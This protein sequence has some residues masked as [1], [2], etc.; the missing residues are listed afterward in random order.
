MR[1]KEAAMNKLPRLP[2]LPG[3]GVRPYRPCPPDFREV[4][5]QLS[6]LREIEEHNPAHAE[7]PAPAKAGVEAG[8]RPRLLRPRGQI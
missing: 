3:G 1:L 2:P 8:P 6:Q 7:L 5:M 4:F